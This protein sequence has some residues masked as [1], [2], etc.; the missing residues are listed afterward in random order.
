MAKTENATTVNTAKENKAPV[1][2]KEQL[3]TS[4]KYANRRDL[5]ESLLEDGKEYAIVTVDEM[6]KKFMKGKVK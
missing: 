5:L 2:T 6:I 1:F 3:K 4:A